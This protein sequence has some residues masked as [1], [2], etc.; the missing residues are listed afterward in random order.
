MLANNIFKLVVASG[1]RIFTLAALV[2]AVYA[3]GL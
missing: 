2:V 1:V 3:F